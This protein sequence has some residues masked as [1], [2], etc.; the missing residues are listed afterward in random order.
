[1]SKEKHLDKNNR[2]ITCIF[3]NSPDMICVEYRGRQFYFDEAEDA[4]KFVDL[5]KRAK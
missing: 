2:E 4:A 5:L 1:M 3:C